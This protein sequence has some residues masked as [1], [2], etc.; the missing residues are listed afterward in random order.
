MTAVNLCVQAGIGIF[1]VQEEKMSLEDIF[2]SLT[3]KQV[4]L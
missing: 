1:R 2:L 3:G 4:S